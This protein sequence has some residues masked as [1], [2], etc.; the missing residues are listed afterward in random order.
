M[1]GRSKG[2]KAEPQ[3]LSARKRKP[4]VLDG[5]ICS[6]FKT[7]KDAEVLIDKKIFLKTFAPAE[8]A[9]YHL[10]ETVSS[11]E[12]RASDFPVIPRCYLVHALVPEG[13]LEDSES[14]L[15]K[16]YQQELR[17]L[18]PF[19]E[20]KTQK[21][22]TEEYERLHEI[23]SRRAEAFVIPESD[24]RAGLRGQQ[25]LRVVQKKG[26]KKGE[27]IAVPYPGHL[28]SKVSKEEVDSLYVL[29]TKIAGG[30][31]KKTLQI[32]PRSGRG[33][34]VL[35]ANPHL[36]NS[37]TTYGVYDD[38]PGPDSKEGRPKIRDNVAFGTVWGAGWRLGIRIMQAIE[39][40]PE[41]TEALID[42]GPAYW[43]M[44]ARNQA[45]DAEALLRKPVQKS[46]RG[47]EKKRAMGASSSP[48]SKLESERELEPELDLELDLQPVHKR[49]AVDSEECRIE[50]PAMGGAGSGSTDSE[51]S[52][53]SKDSNGFF[54]KL[55][56]SML[57]AGDASPE[58]ASSVLFFGSHRG[59]D[60]DISLGLLR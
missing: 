56:R 5:F 35:G 60:K 25:G 7:K 45:I 40:I 43:K 3:R 32:L 27:L 46:S 38:D 44:V 26:I 23:L 41:G 47:A 39:D 58:P 36:V 22:A 31:I 49:I 6:D 37:N 30:S 2:P 10:D 34:F 54:V 55:F 33:P 12:L 50:K 48:D 24:P 1:S 29:D 4:K 17:L 52:E 28:V 59:V 57:R 11:G 42:Y 20:A 9:F 16:V 18:A 13:A 14:K 19:L 51:D 8:R 53:D 15:G 21:E